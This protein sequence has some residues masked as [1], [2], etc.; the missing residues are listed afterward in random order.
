MHPMELIGDVRPLES[1]FD[2]F[3]D[4]VS[5]G[6]RYVDSLRKTDDRL[7]NRFGHTRR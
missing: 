6:G 5:V 7:T 2:Q 3:E 4:S 1:C